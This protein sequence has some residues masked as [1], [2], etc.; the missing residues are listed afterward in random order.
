MRT[1]KIFSRK[2]KIQGINN[3]KDQL[4]TVKL[5]LSAQ[6]NYKD[7]ISI[8]IQKYKKI[9]IRLIKAKRMISVKI[10]QFNDFKCDMMY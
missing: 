6:D 9:Q 1:F 5:S 7:T 8:R 2:L 3:K 4:L 10:M